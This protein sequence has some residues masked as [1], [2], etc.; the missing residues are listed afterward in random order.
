MRTRGVYNI[1]QLLSFSQDKKRKIQRQLTTIFGQ[2][3]WVPMDWTLLAMLKPI[4]KLRIKTKQ[5]KEQF[6][7]A[8]QICGCNE[9][10]YHKDEKMLP[11]FFLWLCKRCGHLIV[12]SKRRIMR[13]ISSSELN[14]A[15]LPVH[16]SFFDT[17][18]NQYQS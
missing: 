2:E 18:S 15:F 9:G 16:S 7:C 1:S 10:S 3:Q 13:Y 6:A 12:K 11:I 5:C 4:S 17:N 8:S 14:S